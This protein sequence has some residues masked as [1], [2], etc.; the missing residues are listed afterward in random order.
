MGQM[1]VDLVPL[2]AV[3]GIKTAFSMQK[4][5]IQYFGLRRLL[6]VKIL[7]QDIFIN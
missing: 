3:F 4:V 7:I 6:I 1:K 2:Q 5:V